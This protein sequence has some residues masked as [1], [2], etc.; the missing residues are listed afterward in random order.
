MKKRIV[1]EEMDK[2]KE[3][4]SSMSIEEKIDKLLALYAIHNISR[5]NFNTVIE[6]LETKTPKIN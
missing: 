5:A 3:V 1:P 2:L 4:I 6:F